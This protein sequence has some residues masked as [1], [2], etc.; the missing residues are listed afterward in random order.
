MYLRRWKRLLLI[1][2]FA[3]L[4]SA[5]CGRPADD[6]VPTLRRGISAQVKTLDPHQSSAAWE[7][8][9]IGDMMIGLMTDGVDGR[10]VPGMAVDWETDESGL[11]W[12]FTLGDY[13]WSDGVPVTAHD[14]EYAMRR[15]QD[16]MIAS[17]YASLLWIIKNAQAVNALEMPPEAL[18]VRA[19]DEKTLE[20]ELEVPAPYLLGMLTHYT[21]FPV[22]RHA[23][24][25][26]GSAWIQPQNI[27]V[28]G[29]YKLVYWRTA[30][31]LAVELNPTGF[32]ASEACFHRVVYFEI[33][34]E[35]AVE[36]KIA[37]G[38]LDINNAF[39]G[40]R[41]A[42]IEARFP[43]WVRTYPGLLT[44]YYS[45]NQR[46]PPFDD[47]RVRKALAMALDREFMVRNVL[48]PGFIPAY[49]FVPPGMN[50]YDVERPSVSWMGMPRAD[51]LIEA[52]RLLEEA[53]FGP[54]NPLRFEYIHRSTGDNPKVAPVAQ[55]NWA[56]IAPWVQP[57]IVR[58]DTQVLYERLRQADFT[59]S[60]GGWLADYDDPLNFLY[61]LLSDTGAQNYGGYA[62]P[63]FDR[64]IHEG[65]RELDLQRR[66]E[67]FAQAEKLMLED[68][69]ITPM[70]FQVT[71]D[72]VDPTL[73]GWAGNAK[74]NHR[75]RFLCRP[76]MRG[77]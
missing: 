52:R 7:N 37:A 70:W 49:S 16:P 14:F 1:P 58:Q 42:E 75:S 9:V 21:T 15:I 62:N 8:I 71:Q 56:E 50:N 40:P 39:S 55:Q 74:N 17:Q 64:L 10:P 72:L 76:G 34:N 53:G 48:T 27:V 22:P 43:G 73:T 61:L 54:Q 32:G 5:G 23:I 67:I 20:I 44:T 11:L 51:R 57:V 12:T 30:D 19:L 46:T 26:H 69:P 13:V 77:N 35:T 68:H 29:P 66:A 31:Q 41:Q 36:N 45:F 4:A 28:N 63:E 33:D 2:V 60:D 3:A 25:Q 47:L 18:G 59:V 24:E 65:N 38:E 6:G